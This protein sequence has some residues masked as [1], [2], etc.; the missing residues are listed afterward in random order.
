M[1]RIA[2]LAA[3]LLAAA[4]SDAAAVRVSDEAPDPIPHLA[5]DPVPDPAPEPQPEPQP[6]PEPDLPALPDVPDA[7]VPPPAPPKPRV[8]V[9]SLPDTMNGK[10]PYTQHDGPPQAFRLRLPTGGFTVEAYLTDAAAPW[11]GEPTFSFS[12]PLR[13]A[14]GDVVPAGDDA[15]PALDCDREPDPLVIAGEEL[16]HTRCRVPDG[17]IDPAPGVTVTAR[18]TGADGAAGEEDSLAFDV[19]ALPAHLDPFPAVDP[20]V[21]MLSRDLFEHEAVARPDGTYDVTSADVPAGNGE[22]DLDEAL[23]ALGLLSQNGEFSAAARAMFLDRVR[24]KSYAIYGLDATGAPLPRGVRVS[25]A[26]EGDPGAPDPAAWTPL[27]PFSRIALGGDP[28]DPESGYVGMAEID[29]NNQGREDDARPGRGVFVTSIV[30]QA[31]RNPLGAQILKEISPVDGTPLGEYPGDEAFL[32]PAFDA[33]SGGDERLAN[34]QLIFGVIMD[35]ATLA[36]AATLCHEMGHSLGLV[37]NGPPP[38]GQF[39]G[40]PGLSLALSDPGDWHIDTPGLNVMQTG[41]VTSYL[42]ALGAEV[43]FEP[44]GLAYLRRQIVT[45]SPSP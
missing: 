26:F 38:E 13:T 20:W 29:P 41:K 35:F 31:L 24:E 17:A 25:I 7:P 44:L 16:L 36:V 45:G 34:R 8:T 40:M 43:R 42:E 28:D 27:S 14:G 6:E 1:R 12:V 22:P 23:R 11:D 18:F 32:D 4:C 5:P 15:R 3:I 19:A 9:A 21:V 39:G 37:A 30:R 10:V 33:S 2:S